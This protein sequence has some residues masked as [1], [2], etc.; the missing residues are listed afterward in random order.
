MD[1]VIAVGGHWELPTGGHYGVWS[2]QWKFL[3]G[4]EPPR[5]ALRTHIPKC[6]R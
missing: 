3:L 4:R 1:A 6:V 2:A 5:S